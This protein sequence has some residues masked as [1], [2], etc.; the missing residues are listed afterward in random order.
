MSMGTTAMVLLQARHNLKA[1]KPVLKARTFKLKG[2]EMVLNY[3]G[4]LEHHRLHQVHHLCNKHQLLG[5]P[6]GRHL[7]RN[8][9]MG[10]L[11]R[12]ICKTVD[13]EKLL[14]DQKEVLGQR[15]KLTYVKPRWKTCLTRIKP[16]QC[17]QHLETAHKER[18]PLLMGAE[19]PMTLSNIK[20]ILRPKMH[21]L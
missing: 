7:V 19:H 15:S 6:L 20:R 10:Y 11:S 5:V 14:R 8:L 3:Q 4:L 16:V 21:L 13:E 18:I 9:L 2:L 12:A 17:L 1:H